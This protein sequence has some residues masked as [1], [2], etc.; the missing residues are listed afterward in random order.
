MAVVAD[1]PPAW[2]FLAPVRTARSQSALGQTVASAGR[3]AGNAAVSSQPH[4]GIELAAADTV[5]VGNRRYRGSRLERL[6]QNLDLLLRAPL[7]PATDSASLAPQASRVPTRCTA[8]C[9][10][11]RYSSLPPLD[12]H[13]DFRCRFRAPRTER[14]NHSRHLA[15]EL[16]GQETLS[17]GTAAIEHEQDLNFG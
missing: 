3:N 13:T 17:E 4:P 9:T 11:R 8:R 10:H 1:E 5:M 15:R 7:P 2:P 14:L 6:G 12:E 16:F